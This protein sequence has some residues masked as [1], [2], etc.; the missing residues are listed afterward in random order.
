VELPKRAGCALVHGALVHEAR[1]VQ[2]TR[3]AESAGST[4]IFMGVQI[5]LW[6][7]RMRAGAVHVRAFGF[8]SPGRARFGFMSGGGG[9][10]PW[11]TADGGP[12]FGFMSPGLSR[13][14][15]HEPGARGRTPQ[16]PPELPENPGAGALA[17]ELPAGFT[18]SGGFT[19]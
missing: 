1:T 8:M 16:K 15:V 3:P 4:N 11:S 7:H 5:F 2:K 18:I 6:V 17:H 10:N 14:W 12:C 13:F 9:C 19:A